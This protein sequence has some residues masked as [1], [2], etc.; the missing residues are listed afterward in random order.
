MSAKRTSTKKSKAPTQQDLKRQ[1]AAREISG[2][3]FRFRFGSKALI[4]HMA[5]LQLQK[6]TLFYN[7]GGARR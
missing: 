2:A 7:S 4:E 3:V 6:W 5:E 1:K